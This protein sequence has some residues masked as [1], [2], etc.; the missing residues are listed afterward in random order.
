M[1]ALVLLIG[2]LATGVSVMAGPK[3]VVEA[4][5]SFRSLIDPLLARQVSQLLISEEKLL[6]LE[7][8]RLY[9]SEVLIE[10]LWQQARRSR[11]MKDKVE[12]YRQ[13]SLTCLSTIE[14]SVPAIA[15]ALAK[16]KLSVPAEPLKVRSQILLSLAAAYRDDLTKERFPVDEKP[17]KTLEPTPGL[18]M[19]R[20]EPRVTPSPGV[21]HL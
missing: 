3:A 4:S 5:A 8:D 21:A 12:E 9:R 7:L 11:G 10:V 19:P 16:T 13:T 15:A 20:A 14:H 18:V 2:V 1:K 6:R 17:N